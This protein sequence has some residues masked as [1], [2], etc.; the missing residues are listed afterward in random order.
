MMRVAE[1]QIPVHPYLP[2]GWIGLPR[3]SYLLGYQILPSSWSLVMGPCWSTQSRPIVPRGV[4]CRV[5]RTSLGRIKG[6]ER[7]PPLNFP[8]ASR[9]IVSCHSAVDVV[10][11]SERS[12]QL[13]YIA[14]E[15]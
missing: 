7:L 9:R 8:R 6:F 15:S 14:T 3:A 5:F 2:T 12:S 1:D 10:S 13:I 11:R 4:I